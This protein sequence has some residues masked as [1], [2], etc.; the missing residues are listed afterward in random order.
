MINLPKAGF[1]SAQPVTKST[2]TNNEDQA[3]RANLSG[4]ARGYTIPTVHPSGSQDVVCRL[5]GAPRPFQ[6]VREV[7]TISRILLL[8]FLS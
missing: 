8:P 4:L 6:G 1:H 7:K 5:L 3:E 2:A